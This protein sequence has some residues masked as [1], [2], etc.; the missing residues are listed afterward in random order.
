MYIGVDLG[1]TN[2]KAAIYNKEMKLVDRQS[3][4]VRY[5]RENGFVEFDGEQYFEE[6]L[7]LL[8]KMLAENAVSTVEEI[9]FTGQAESLVVL[10]SQGKPLMNVISW[11]DERSAAQCGALAEM[12]SPALCEEVTGQKAVL[13][14]WHATKIL[15]MK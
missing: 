7:R 10:D 11:M 6:L 2:M 12:F 3:L 9:A 5:I 8:G 14:N 13:P 4:P 1:S 15:W